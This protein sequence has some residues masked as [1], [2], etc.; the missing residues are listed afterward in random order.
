M[1]NW[2]RILIFSTTFYLSTTFNVCV[3]VCVGERERET[4]NACSSSSMMSFGSVHP[5][6]SL[7]WDA[8]LSVYGWALVF[9]FPLSRL[10]QT[11]TFAMRDSLY[12]R[13]LMMAVTVPAL[14]RCSW[15][16]L[17]WISS[18]WLCLTLVTISIPGNWFLTSGSQALITIK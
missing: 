6:R 9:R 15:E 3:C 4:L 1:K 12:V 16:S 2:Q 5:S 10:C 18:L 17:L 13:C 7:F 14:D 11:L 8:L